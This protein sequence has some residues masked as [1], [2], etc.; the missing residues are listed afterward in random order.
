VT[1]TCEFG[2]DLLFQ[3]GPIIRVRVGWDPNFKPNETGAPK[4]PTDGYR[5]ILDTG[6]SY[7]SIDGALAT[8]L[9]LPIVGRGNIDGTGGSHNTPIHMATVY[10][11]QFG[12]T[13]YGQFH[14]VNLTRGRHVLLGRKFLQHFTMTYEGRTGT[15]T[16][17]KD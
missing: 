5:A 15:I 9:N 1:I 17:S 3:D 11:P 7:S 10:V 2:S 8:R 4:I 13:H 14:A 6:A 16:L 12:F